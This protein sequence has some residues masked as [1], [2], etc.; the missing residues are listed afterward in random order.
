[1]KKQEAIEVVQQDSEEI[2]TSVRDV[3]MPL[4]RHKWKMLL[5]F[6]FVVTTIA[7]ILYKLPSVY[8]S[9][10]QIHI[11][12]GRELISLDTAVVGKQSTMSPRGV[13]IRNELAI[14]VPG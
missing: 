10:A 12:L 4:F 6:I 8:E 13:E 11:K 5:F 14:L 7:A 9:K 1:M 3:L 2:R